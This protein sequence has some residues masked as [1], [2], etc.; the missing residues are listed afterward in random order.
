[1]GEELDGK[2]QDVVLKDAMSTHEQE[3]RIMTR[4]VV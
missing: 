1:M 4:C 3:A 2:I